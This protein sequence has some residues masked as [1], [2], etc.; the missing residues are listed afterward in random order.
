MGSPTSPHAQVSLSDKSAQG[1][2]FQS[3]LGT[4]LGLPE[5]PSTFSQYAIK[6]ILSFDSQFIFIPGTRL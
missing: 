4:S 5:F 6:D 1:S 2:D 3:W